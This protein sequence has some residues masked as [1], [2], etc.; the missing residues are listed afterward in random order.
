M[1]V[2]DVHSYPSENTSHQK[3]FQAKIPGVNMILMTH[4]HVYVPT[5]PM[6]NPYVDDLLQYKDY[7]RYIPIYNFVLIS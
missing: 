5:T 2:G 4:T 3:A 1:F 6:N 7:C